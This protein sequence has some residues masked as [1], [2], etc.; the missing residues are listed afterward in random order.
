MPAII[1]PYYCV[2]GGWVT[3]Y[4]AVFLSG[5]AKEAATDGFFGGFIT[6]TFEPI[7]WFLIFLGLTAL[8]VLFG[9]EKGIEKVSKIMMP[10]LVVL[11]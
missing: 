3:K 10:V 9:V 2:I 11:T 1:L 7:G 8:I 4:L 6:S 5:G